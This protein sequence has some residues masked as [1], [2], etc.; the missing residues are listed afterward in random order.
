M[1]RDFP[2]EDLQGPLV[3]DDVVQ[4]H[5]QQVVAIA[6]AE[7]ARRMGGG[8][9]GEGPP[10]LGMG[11]A[12]GLRLAEPRGHVAEV[13]PLDRHGDGP[14]GGDGLDRPTLDGAD[15]GPQG[16]VPAHDGVDRRL[17]TQGHRS[18]LET[19]AQRDVVGRVARPQPV[20]E[21]EAFLR[22]RGGWGVVR[23]GQPRR[24]SGGH[25]PARPGRSGR[26][27]P[28]A[29]AGDGRRLEQRTR[30]G[31]STPNSRPDP[32]DDADRQQRVP[33]QLEEV[34]VDADAPRPRASDQIPANRDSV[35]SRGA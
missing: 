8:P 33:A 21:P 26:P 4:G 13:L 32:G 27:R 24:S 1:G 16:C 5:H 20:Q 22:E 35:G 28:G 6:E 34:R 15:G 7:Q 14:R 12:G 25:H 10:G 3:A 17:E 9:R 11:P 23:A 29:Q 30:T 19:R 18:S 2:N 31:S